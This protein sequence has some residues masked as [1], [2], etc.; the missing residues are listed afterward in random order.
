MSLKKKKHSVQFFLARNFQKFVQNPDHNRCEQI[1]ILI[2]C[3][4][5]YAFVLITPKEKL[6]KRAATIIK[7]GFFLKKKLHQRSD[8]RLNEK[9]TNEANS[10]IKS[11]AT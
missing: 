4:A 3:W 1:F 2:R 7:Y 10:S 8:K 5:T 11:A 6:Q 9:K